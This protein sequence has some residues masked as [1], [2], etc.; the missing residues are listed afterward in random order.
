MEAVCSDVMPLLWL[1]RPRRRTWQVERHATTPDGQLER[2]DQGILRRHGCNYREILAIVACQDERHEST[3]RFCPI[4]LRSGVERNAIGLGS[5]S[6]FS[7]DDRRKGW[8]G[9]EKDCTGPSNYRKFICQ[10]TLESA[11]EGIS[12]V[13]PALPDIADPRILSRGTETETDCE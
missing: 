8:T 4:K 6:W 2:R 9:M 11:T 10:T 5:A 7:Q 12:P 13:P 3:V 1:R